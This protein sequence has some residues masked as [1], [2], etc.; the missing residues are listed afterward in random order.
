MR[1]GWSLDFKSSGQ[2][3]VDPKDDMWLRSKPI[4]FLTDSHVSGELF[5]AYRLLIKVIT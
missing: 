3:E 2:A 4:Q 5:G 1:E